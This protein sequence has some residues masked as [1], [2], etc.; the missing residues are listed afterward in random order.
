VFPV[1][2]SGK[3]TKLFIVSTPQGF[4]LFYKLFIAAEHKKNNYKHLAYTW[5]DVFFARNPNAT[6]ADAMKWRDDTIKA[7]ANDVSKFQQEFE[8][9]FLGSANS[10]I[11]PWKIA[12]LGYH[13]P[14]E[15]R[16]PLR[17]YEKPIYL[18]EDGPAHVYICTVDVAQGQEKDSS[19][20]QVIDITNHPFKQVAVYQ[21]N[22]IKPAQLAPVCVQIAQWYND[23]FLFFEINGEAFATAQICNE[24]LEY[25][26]IIQVFPHKKKGQQLSSGFH[27]TA[28]IGLKSSEATK[29]VGATG[30][31]SLVENDQLLICDYDTIQQITT[32]VG[33]L[34]KKTGLATIYEAE[35][36]NHDDLV[37]PLVLLGWLTLQSG[38]ENYVGLNMRKLLAEGRD[39]LDIEPPHPG[40]FDIN[41][42]DPYLPET[43]GISQGGFE[44]I[45]DK[46]FWL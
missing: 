29:R 27:P 26:N 25:S 23:A 36:G 14:V 15:L 30:L 6:E 2:S 13:D 24:E 9:D 46:D 18:S 8:C 3:T 19:V 43:I 32:F 40:F 39:P 5:R 42:R 21:D 45:D 20:V 1:I 22:S 34:N 11:A 16:G 38:F 10:L 28:R 41:A 37:I 4:N 35:V 17:I 44:V 31:K 12:Q 7:M 33:K